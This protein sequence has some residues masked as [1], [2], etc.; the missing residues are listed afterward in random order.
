[1]YKVE[2]IKTWNL[3]P[4]RLDIYVAFVKRRDPHSPAKWLLLHCSFKDANKDNLPHNV[5]SNLFIVQMIPNS[6]ANKNA[7][8]YM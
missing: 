5:K 1:M 2:S 3:I 6:D 7:Y 8:M 4:M